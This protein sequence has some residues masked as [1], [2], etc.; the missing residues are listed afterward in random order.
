VVS[1]GAGASHGGNA[2]LDDVGSLV[3]I[4]GV[5]AG[6]VASIVT[7][8][9]DKEKVTWPKWAKK[10]K[11]WKLLLVFAV[12]GAVSTGLTF[13]GYL[14]AK[15]TGDAVK[16]GGVDLSGYCSSYDFTG[17]KDMGCES[18]IDLGDACDKRW[19]RHGDS[20]RFTDPDDQTSGVC[21]TA[22]GRDTTKGVDNLPDYC[23]QKYPLSTRVTAVSRAPHHW[24]CRA[25]I[26]PVLM[27][28]W[29]YQSRD[30]VA[31]LNPGGQWECYEEKPL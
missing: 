25:D 12:V 3:G 26:D 29:R 8:L 16:L 23:R 15:G 24:F 14:I 18:G 22:S 17:P 20:M 10:K 9:V 21:Y 28:S 5:L 19:S 30:A 6:A 2:V 27:C 31:R 11:W 13:G 4:V 1:G 7:V